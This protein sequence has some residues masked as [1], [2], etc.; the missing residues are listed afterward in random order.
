M[1]VVLDTVDRNRRD[2][3]SQNP[4]PI[5]PNQQLTRTNIHQIIT[6][7]YKKLS[8][9]YI[10][11][12]RSTAPNSVDHDSCGL[13]LKKLL[14]WVSLQKIP[15][16]TWDF[17]L[18][19]LCIYKRIVSPKI[20]QAFRSITVRRL[21]LGSRIHIK[22]AGWLKTG[23]R[24]VP[25][26]IKDWCKRTC[27]ALR[28]HATHIFQNTNISGYHAAIRFQYVSQ[29]LSLQ[30]NFNNYMVPTPLHP[31]F[32]LKHLQKV[33]QHHIPPVVIIFASLLITCQETYTRPLSQ[34]LSKKHWLHHSI[35]QSR[36]LPHVL[37]R[38]AMSLQHHKQSMPGR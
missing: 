4:S 8:K 34:V 38:K 15:K 30:T 32:Q 2:P 16:M 23:C 31:F 1:S 7:P 14:A 11:C 25:M 37:L 33:L 10:I 36:R 12:G 27:F 19:E 24:D 28:F 22:F 13:C 20:P 35:A 5:I 17:F 18:G 26:L 21:I 3:I 9:S 29:P 6:T